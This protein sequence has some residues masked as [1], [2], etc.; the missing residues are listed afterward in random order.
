MQKASQNK[1]LVMS[2]TA[3]VTADYTVQRHNMV[4][5]QVRPSDVVDRRLLKAMTDVPRELYVP[6]DRRAVAYMDEAI[7]LGAG[8]VLLAPRTFAKLVAL[9]DLPDDATVLDVGAGLGYSTAVLCRFVKSV[10]TLEVADHFARAAEAT[11]KA[12]GMTNA[13]V[14][15]GPLALG[16]ATRAPYDAILI[17]G[18]LNDPSPGLLDQLKDGGKLIAVR[19]AGAHAKACVWHRAGSNVTMR[20][21]FDMSAP[22]LPGFEAKPQFVF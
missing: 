15:T 1:P 22:L 14:V 19:G 2:P 7:P 20:E 21:A 11:F 16:H 3:T 9:A 12:Q 6:E 18:A 17:N 13:T 4:E 8:R 5:S 10:T